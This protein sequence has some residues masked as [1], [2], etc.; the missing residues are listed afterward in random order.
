MITSR[1]QIE[2]WPL[3]LIDLDDEEQISVVSLRKL[4]GKN[5]VIL[6]INEIIYF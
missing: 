2:I 4:G 1:K 5:A 3:R 6:T